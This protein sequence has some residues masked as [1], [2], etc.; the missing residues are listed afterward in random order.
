MS[1]AVLAAFASDVRAAL[2]PWNVEYIGA[3]QVADVENVLV[4][5]LHRHGRLKTAARPA[6]SS[7]SPS[8]ADWVAKRT[9]HAEKG[10]E[11]LAT[12]CE[13]STRHMLPSS[14]SQVIDVNKASA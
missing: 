12:E 6:L 3:D 14:A 2:V 1:M 13:A 5:F 7:L 10:P 11:C 8:H 4:C 9:E